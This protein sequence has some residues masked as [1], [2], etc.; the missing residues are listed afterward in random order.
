MTIKE[1][2]IQAHMTQAEMAEEFG[3]PKRSIENW[4]GGQRECPAYV[5]EMLI[6]KLQQIVK[7]ARIKIGS[8]DGLNGI[9]C[10]LYD[11]ESDGW[12]LSW[13]VPMQHDGL[14]SATVVDK[15]TE[16]IEEGYKVI[17]CY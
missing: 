7:T 12:D 9:F 15:I 10:E 8:F 3:I 1:A 5:E 14:I 6:E 17:R 4:E 2:R 13:F 16:L 11:I